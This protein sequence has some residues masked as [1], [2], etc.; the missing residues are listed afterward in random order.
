M[1]KE[2]ST[3]R[4]ATILPIVLDQ[5]SPEGVAAAPA[6]ASSF[7]AAVRAVAGL[8]HAY[9]QWLVALV[10]TAPDAAALRVRSMG[11]DW[12][13]ALDVLA[14]V[15]VVAGVLADRLRDPAAAVSRARE[16][17]VVTPIAQSSRCSSSGAAGRAV[18]LVVVD[19]ASFVGGSRDRV[20]PAS[21]RAAACGIPIAVVSADRPLE[22]V[23]AG[24]LVGVARA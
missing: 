13:V 19:S 7:D 12:E 21:L 6:G 23:L 16:I 9:V 4:L 18:S 2:A 15:E 8:T 3:M 22:Q 20:D 1:V 5:W 10:G 11:H 17:V 14:A 24:N